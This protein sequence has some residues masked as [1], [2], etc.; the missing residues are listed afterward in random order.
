MPSIFGSHSISKLR[1]DDVSRLE[2]FL[3]SNIA[4]ELMR[5]I[6]SI[7]DLLTQGY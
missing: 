3:L 2:I 6:F 7:A 1:I 5:M 4:P